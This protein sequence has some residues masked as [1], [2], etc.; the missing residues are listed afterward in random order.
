M[1]GAVTYG[2]PEVMNIDE[3]HRLFADEIRFAANI[4][5]PALIEAFARVPRE[6]F[7]GPVQPSVDQISFRDLRQALVLTGARRL[8]S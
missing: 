8:T 2:I 7:L 3:C 4:T 6:Q 1:V 5:S